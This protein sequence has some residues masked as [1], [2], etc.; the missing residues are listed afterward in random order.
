MFHVSSSTTTWRS[1]G[2]WILVPLREGPLGHVVGSTQQKN[3]R[4]ESGTLSERFLHEMCADVEANH[5]AAVT[6]RS[7]R[8][9]CKQLGYKTY[10]VRAQALA[11]NPCESLSGH[12]F[13]RSPRAVARRSIE[14]R[15]RLPILCHTGRNE[16]SG[17]KRALKISFFQKSCR[18]SL[19]VHRLTSANEVRASATA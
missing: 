18:R 16:I 9:P 10:L 3:P 6:C 5:N 1:L 11:E 2:G 8:S 13:R 19:S 17:Q 7:C 4:P 12:R 15:M 14:R